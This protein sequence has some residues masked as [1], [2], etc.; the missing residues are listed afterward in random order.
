[1][2]EKMRKLEERRRRGVMLRA[3]VKGMSMRSRGAG[4]RLLMNAAIHGT[5]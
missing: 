4:G 5:E 1:M 2:E 3:T